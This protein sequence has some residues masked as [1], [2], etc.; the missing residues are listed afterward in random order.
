MTYFIFMKFNIIL[1]VDFRT[2]Q[3][4]DFLQISVLYRL[5]ITVVRKTRV[6]FLRS[7]QAFLDKFDNKS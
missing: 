2:L 1:A 6:D 4:P 7:A 5:H 3:L